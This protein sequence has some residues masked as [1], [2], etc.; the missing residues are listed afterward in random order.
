MIYY[1]GKVG[2]ER[3]ESGESEK[4]PAP[5]GNRTLDLSVT[6]RV[7]YRCAAALIFFIQYNSRCLKI[8]SHLYGEKGGSVPL[9]NQLPRVQICLLVKIEPENSSFHDTK[10]HPN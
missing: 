1:E 6:R 5:G 3:K 8:S 2:K 9:R 4:S 10:A 7:L